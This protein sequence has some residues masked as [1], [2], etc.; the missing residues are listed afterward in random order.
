[1]LW[2]PNDPHEGEVAGTSVSSETGERVQERRTVS[3][4]SVVNHKYFP[5]SYHG[6]QHGKAIS[7]YSFCV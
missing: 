1:M 6:A 3:K 4:I 5:L 2:P 7:V